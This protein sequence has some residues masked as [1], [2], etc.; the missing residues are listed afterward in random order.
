MPYQIAET[1]SERS[2]EAARLASK[3]SSSLWGVARG[4]LVRREISFADPEG[5]L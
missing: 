3:Q 1:S 5:G 4:K 2:C